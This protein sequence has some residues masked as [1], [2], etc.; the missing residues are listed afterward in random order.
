MHWPV[1]R[2]SPSSLVPA[3]R[4]SSPIAET[5]LLA[6]SVKGCVRAAELGRTTIYEAIKNGDLKSFKVGRRRLVRVAALE[7]WLASLEQ[8]S[9]R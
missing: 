9:A 2:C 7:A 5:P 1:V 6:L 8:R 3:M 4:K